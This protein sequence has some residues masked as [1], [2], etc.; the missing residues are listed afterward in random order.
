[1]SLFGGT[2]AVLVAGFLTVAVFDVDAV[3]VEEV[4][5]VVV[6][7]FTVDFLA[8]VVEELLE[9][10]AALE[11]V[12][13]VLDV[14]VCSLIAILEDVLDDVE[15]AC[16]GVVGELSLIG[17]DIGE[18][19]SF[20][21]VFETVELDLTRV[22]WGLE[23]VDVDVEV[24]VFWS[25]EVEAEVLIALRGVEGEEVA[26][27]GVLSVLLEEV[28]GVRDEVTLVLLRSWFPLGESFLVCVVLTLLAFTLTLSSLSVFL[29]ETTLP[30]SLLA[31]E[32][33][34][35]FPPSC[36]MASFE[37]DLTSPTF[38]VISLSVVCSEVPFS[39][40]TSEFIALFYTM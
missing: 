25:L 5:V 2:T 24:V 27:E 36:F 12:V 17:E 31:I 40:G 38:T 19:G 4:P 26:E 28:V 35:S 34:S 13:D 39:E 7:V 11:A 29:E 18:L 33:V 14:T 20:C 21:V 9:E 10:V 32:E 16:R 15:V 37:G 8:V 30:V 6:E 22:F 1:M 3:D 23:V